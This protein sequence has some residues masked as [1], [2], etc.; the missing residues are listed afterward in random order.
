MADLRALP[1]FAD[2]PPGCIV[3][4]VTS[5]DHAPHLRAGEFAVV[6]RGA[7]DPLQ[8][9]IYAR[10]ITDALS[11]TGRRLGLWQVTRRAFQ[12]ATGRELW[13]FRKS[14][15]SLLDGPVGR[16]T[17]PQAVVGCVIGLY[18]PVA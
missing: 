8:G 13:W 5:D 14:E 7:R 6:D 17:F 10:F 18:E 1:I 15:G 11:E 2:V 16:D 4:P 3:L 12:C 9:E